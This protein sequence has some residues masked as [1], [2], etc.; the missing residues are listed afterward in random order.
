[1]K[2]PADRGRHPRGAGL[3]GLR[4]G[5]GAVASLLAGQHDHGPRRQRAVLAAVALAGRLVRTAAPA[6][7]RIRCFVVVL[8]LLLLLLLL[9]CRCFFVVAIVVIPWQV[10]VFI[11][12]AVAVVVARKWPLARPPRPYQGSDAGEERK[13]DFR[14]NRR[15]ATC[16]EL[17]SLVDCLM[18]AGSLLTYLTDCNEWRRTRR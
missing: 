6:H 16:A 9:S 17:R 3:R 13:K 18:I 12:A 11:F 14:T 7:R 8:I 5:P 10:P 4:R 15:P 1:M 2:A